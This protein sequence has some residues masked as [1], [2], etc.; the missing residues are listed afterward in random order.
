[1]GDIILDEDQL[2]AAW[3]TRFTEYS[4]N[5]HTYAR[6]CFHTLLGQALRG[7]RVYKHG[8]DI[9]G[10]FSFF[11]VQSSGSGKST[12]L[13]F[14]IRICKALGLDF[15]SV[16]DWSDA[17]L[18]GTYDK[19]EEEDREVLEKVEGLLGSIDIMH[20]DEATLLFTPSK[21]NQ[22]T[23]SYLQM[24]L[25]PIDS[26]SNEI[27]KK[28]AKGDMIT[29]TPHLSLFLTSY[30]PSNVNELITKRGILQRIAV[31]VRFLDADERLAN[32]LKDVEYLGV[33]TE[34]KE[35]L[36]DQIVET[37]RHI[38]DFYENREIEFDM[39]VKPFLRGRVRD[40]FKRAAN[41]NPQIQEHIYSFLPRYMTMMYVVALHHAAMRMSLKVEVDDVKYAYT[42]IRTLFDSIISWLEEELA[43]EM[44]RK[45]RAKESLV[46]YGVKVFRDNDAT[47]MSLPKFI[48]L[49]GIVA[50]RSTSTC[51]RDIKTPAF[52]KAFEIDLNSKT[53]KMRKNGSKSKTISTGD[54]SF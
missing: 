47:S 35:H 18:V 40:L 27:H 46:K 13:S 48:Q 50:G 10:R 11:L 20:V 32:A 2:T 31:F 14:V 4:Y 52:T 51:Y 34:D 15:S 43:L 53:I 36:E 17:A 3:D 25:N 21:Y 1:M 26:P 42:F 6:L 9:D 45:N 8:I 16:A 44:N 30:N 29:V 28:L 38:K 49:Y 19:K 33:K 37:L 12:P 24:A 23:L 7:Q 54:I 39:N 22:Q 41:V 5:N